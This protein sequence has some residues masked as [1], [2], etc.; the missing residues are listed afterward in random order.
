MK[1]NIYN[2]Y[3]NKKRC[4]GIFFKI[5]YLVIIT[6]FFTGCTMFKAYLNLDENLIN[7]SY[8]AADKL[9]DRSIPPIS[10]ASPV[11]IATLTDVQSLEDTSL[12]GKTVS[13]QIS[14]R[15]VQ[16]GYKVVELKLRKAVLVNSDRGELL[17]SRI[18][19]DIAKE[20]DAQYAMVGTY[21]IGNYL[22]YVSAKIV[23]LS[24]NTIIS[25][26]NY[27]LPLGANNRKLLNLSS[28]EWKFVRPN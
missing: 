28:G 3:K 16:R 25:T 17:L 8:T 15:L 24:D 26:Y 12:F 19:Q 18:A 7:E 22:I 13:E 27:K 21:S 1:L 20:H 2:L 23:K 10:P 9:I 6:M 11:L 14:S 4:A 5:L